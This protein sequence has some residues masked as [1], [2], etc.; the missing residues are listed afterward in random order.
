MLDITTLF[1]SVDD[2]W[3][4]FKNDWY[5]KQI[6]HKPS[7]GPSCSISMS[8]IMTIMILFHQSNFRN[9]KHFYIFLLQERKKRIS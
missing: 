9:F 4:T 7:R 6:I 3:K 8:E 5:K 1:C 2:F